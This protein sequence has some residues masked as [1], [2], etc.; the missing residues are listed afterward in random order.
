MS[1]AA[2][3]L[4]QLAQRRDRASLLRVERVL[5]ALGAG[6]PDRAAV[7]A[8]GEALLQR[9]LLRGGAGAA[10][11]VVAAGSDVAGGCRGRLGRR[12]RGRL[13]VVAAAGGEQERE[14]G[15]ARAGEQACG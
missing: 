14:A 15:R 11:S 6:E 5:V 8:V 3:V 4:A 12:R 13:L 2:A 9:R 10:G 1:G 7:H